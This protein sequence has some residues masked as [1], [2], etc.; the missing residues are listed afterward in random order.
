MSS[1]SNHWRIS[2]AHS[3]LPRDSAS[4]LVGGVP[5]D[6]AKFTSSIA[7]DQRFGEDIGVL[8][9]VHSYADGDLVEHLLIWNEANQWRLQL[10]I[11]TRL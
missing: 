2:A 7:T 1:P 4:G 11:I 3:L 5:D 6:V 8:P 9:G 10:M